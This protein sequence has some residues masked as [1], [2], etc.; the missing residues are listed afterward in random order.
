MGCN[1]AT[2]R[3]AFRLTVED[4]IEQTISLARIERRL[5]R[6]RGSRRL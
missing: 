1:P 3:R 2:G 4:T 5:P 6:N